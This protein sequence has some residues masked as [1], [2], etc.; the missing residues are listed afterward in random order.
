MFIPWRVIL[1]R[2]WLQMA[3]K[4]ADP[5]IVSLQILSE[6]FARS[7]TVRALTLDNFRHISDN[8]FFCEKM[9]STESASVVK[10]GC[11]VVREWYEK[12]G[13]VYPVLQTSFSF[14]QSQK[15]NFDSG[16]IERTETLPAVPAVAE[17][18]QTWVADAISETESS[19]RELESLMEIIL[20][21]AACGGKEEVDDR[22]RTVPTASTAPIVLELNLKMT[23]IRRDDTTREIERAI[24]SRVALNFRNWVGK[25]SICEKN[26]DP[27][28]SQ[29]SPAWTRR[30]RVSRLGFRANLIGQTGGSPK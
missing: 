27:N 6:L 20:P 21:F 9:T 7:A 2:L 11:R 13:H 24:K 26:V 17:R 15:V 1:D 29:S 3:K 16:S 18:L 23:K 12:F 28:V 14:L 8:I 5:K 25:G 4:A 22:L 30:L 19:V 10:E